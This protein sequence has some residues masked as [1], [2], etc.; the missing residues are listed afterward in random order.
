[1]NMNEIDESEVAQSYSTL[2]DP[3]DQAPPPMEFSR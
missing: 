2:C 3:K 1:M